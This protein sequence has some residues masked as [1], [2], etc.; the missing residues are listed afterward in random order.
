M[1]RKDIRSICIQ[2]FIKL[3]FPQKDFHDAPAK[4]KKTRMGIYQYDNGALRDSMSDAALAPEL[5]MTARLKNAI[6]V[7]Q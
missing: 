2:F 3:G 6:P 5:E 7:Y 1:E 4:I